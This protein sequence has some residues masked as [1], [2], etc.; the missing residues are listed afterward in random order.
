MALLRRGSRR[1]FGAALY[2]EL[3]QGRLSCVRCT[4]AVAFRALNCPEKYAAAGKGDLRDCENV[5]VMMNYN[6]IRRKT[7]KIRVGRV[8]VG[9]DA[10]VAVQSMLNV[11]GNDYD[12]VMHQLKALENAGCDIVRMSVPDM[13]TVRVLGRVKESGFPLPLVADIH[14]DYRMAVEAAAAGADKIR[15]NPG[16][17]GSKERIRAVVAACRTHGIP[18]RI[19]V[20]GGSLEKDLMAKY[21]APTAEALTESARR[22]ISLLEELDFHDILIAIKSSRVPEMIRANELIAG[23]YPYPVHLGVTEAGT[24]HM[25]L[26]KSSV[27]IGALL[28]RGIGDTIRVSLTAPPEEE[29]REGKALLRALGMDSSYR[30]NFVSCPT[31][32]R[33][34]VDII[35]IAGEVEARAEAEGLTGKPLTVAVMGCAVNGPGEARNADIGI[36]G[37]NGEAILIRKGEILR[38]IP[39]DRIVDELLEEIRKLQ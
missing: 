13:E 12:A 5:G 33:T 4:A 21:G 39:E 31:C 26:I 3:R 7:K 1:R 37:G 19:G 32:G 23:Q 16:N 34:R 29:V 14:F 17:I 28:C 11:P 9:G 38:K 22:H 2:F 20:N 6:Q 8:M 24:P 30:M 18:I 27:G 35:R 10:P 25:G 36:A 15:I